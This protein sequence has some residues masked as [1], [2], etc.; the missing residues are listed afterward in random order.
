MCA[1]FQLM[2]TFRR[3]LRD[4]SPLDDA[5]TG[6]NGY[7]PFSLHRRLPSR[8]LTECLIKTCSNPFMDALRAKEKNGSSGL[9]IGP[10]AAATPP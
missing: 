9:S 2:G 3:E 6:A 4:F 7:R 5:C 1:S 8:K 10:L